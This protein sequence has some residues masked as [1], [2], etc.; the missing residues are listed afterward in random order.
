MFLLLPLWVE[1][2]N[3]EDIRQTLLQSSL[4]QVQ[5]KVYLHTD[6]QCYFVGDTL[7]Y[8]AY[9]VRA[10]NLKP[11]DLSRILYVELLSPDGLLVE[12]QQI[13]VNPK[14][15]TC[16]QFVLTDSL[17]SGY[18]EMRA[19]TRW[20]LNFNVRHHQYSTQDAWWFYN[21]DM[22]ADY[23]RV[24]DGLYSRVLP[25]YSKPEQAGDYDV[26]TMYQRPKTRLPRKKKDDLVVKFYPEGGHLVSGVE[27]RVAFEVCDQFGEAVDVKGVVSDGQQS[28]DIQTEYMGRGSFVVTPKGQRLKAT[29]QWRDKKWS[30]SLPKEEEQGVALRLDKN[31]LT[32]NTSGVPQEQ[33]YAV[34][35]LCRGALKHFENSSQNPSNE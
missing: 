5:E 21:K 14:G 20:M 24:W 29:F 33:E 28:I 15:Y 1:A 2:G 27:N 10:D 9:V 13:V 7:W 26:R 30:E 8:K 32:I 19:Y 4:S 11:T 25:V 22:A 34:S 6:N 18:Y 23:F 16:G 3:I 17:Y 35:I 12:R 31:R